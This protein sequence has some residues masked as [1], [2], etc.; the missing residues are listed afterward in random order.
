VAPVV[1]SSAPVVAERRRGWAAAKLGRVLHYWT[2]AT[3]TTPL[4]EVRLT[5]P[6]LRTAPNDGSKRRRC[7]ACVTAHEVK[8]YVEA[9]IYGDSPD[10]HKIVWRRES[11]FGR[12]YTCAP[13]AADTEAVRIVG[14]F[15]GRSQGGELVTFTATCLP[16]AKAITRPREMGKE[17]RARCMPGVTIKLYRPS[18]RRDTCAICLRNARPEMLALWRDGGLGLI[19]GGCIEG[20]TAAIAAKN[21][22]PTSGDST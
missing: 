18:D 17:T 8:T 22:A 16:C 1:D 10:P 2:N 19:C 4:C 12:C 6:L 15:R 7:P 21:E 11:C 13:L 3:D 9:N 20:M 5:S 14:W